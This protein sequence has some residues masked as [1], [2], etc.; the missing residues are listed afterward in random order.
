MNPT[1]D[2]EKLSF[3]ENNAYLTKKWGLKQGLNKGLKRKG[4]KNMYYRMGR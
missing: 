2:K 4:D 1:N 3:F